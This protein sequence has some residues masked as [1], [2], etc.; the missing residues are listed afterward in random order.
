MQADLTRFFGIRSALVKKRLP[1]YKL[2]V[3]DKRRIALYKTKGGALVY[4][5]IGSSDGFL[6]KN[7]PASYLFDYTNLRFLLG[8]KDNEK[9]RESPPVWDAT[10]LGFNLDLKFTADLESLESVMRELRKIGLDITLAGEEVEII[11]IEDAEN[12]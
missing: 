1:V 11:E 2:I 3:R 4:E 5:K 10:N 6:C 12:N 9:V 7:V 8:G